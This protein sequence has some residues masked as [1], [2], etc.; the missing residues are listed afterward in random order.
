MRIH[1]P[2]CGVKGSLDD[3]FAGR[4]IQCPK[5]KELFTAGQELE[6]PQD[7]M[8]DMANNSSAPDTV[9][10]ER[11]A[12]ATELPEVPETGKSVAEV[13]DQSAP[14]VVP[15]RIAETAESEITDKP[16]GAVLD[17]SP[18]PPPL[19]A[20]AGGAVVVG[21]GAHKEPDE[22][23]SSSE[24]VEEPAYRERQFTVGQALSKAWD[25]TSGVKG[26]ILGGLLITY[27]FSAVLI[28]VLDMLISNTGAS[29]V[30]LLN[31][32][33]QII[34][35]A[36]SILFTAGLMFM[37]VKRATGR[38]VAWKDVFSGFDMAGKIL[39]AGFLQ[40]ALIIIGFMLLILPGVYLMIGYLLCFPLII[41]KKM[42][43]WEAM[44]T[45]RKAIH[46]VWWKI[47]GLYIIILLIVGISA[48]P[49]GIG[50]I[51]TGPMSVILCGVVYNYLFYTKKKS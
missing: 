28:G 5:C 45:S 34:N 24:I 26:P 23:L 1:C 27:G 10:P 30:G 21:E 47:F 16:E 46:K 50:L 22:E 8:P 15:E 33:G 18:Q 36:M 19:E 41:D 13:V 3:K 9:E 12:A 29:E 20:G 39:V 44:E 25:L 31:M 17:E 11:P 32:A 43:P 14:E 40:G 51:W 4:K 37:G 48:L 6:V 35:S 38:V 49:L 2:H 7:T 42:S